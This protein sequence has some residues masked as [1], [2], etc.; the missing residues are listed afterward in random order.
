MVQLYDCTFVH[1]NVDDTVVWLHLYT[2]YSVQRYRHT[3]VP[4]TLHCTNVVIQLY[5]Q[6]Y[7]VQMYSHTTVPST[8]QYTNVVIQLYVDCT[9]VWLVLMVQLY[10]CTFVHCNVDGTVVW[11]VLMVQLYDCTFVH[12]VHMYSHTTVPSTL[13]CTNEQSYNCTI[14]ITV[15]IC[16]HTTVPSLLQCTNVVTFIHCNVDCTVV[17]LVLMV[18]LYDCT[19]VHCNVDGTVVWLVLI[20]TL[21]CTHVQSYNCTI[22]ITVYKWTVIQLYHQHYSVHM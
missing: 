10:D 1:C 14:N 16:S 9:V 18:Q 20:S 4:S 15:Y 6:H 7:S 17:W 11:L 3:T 8:L 21:Q 5:H 19:F 22:N 12:S 13:Q 2:H